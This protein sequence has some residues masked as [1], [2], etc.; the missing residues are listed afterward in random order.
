[1]TP[2]AGPAYVA[3]VLMHYVDLPDTP[4]RPTPQDQAIA[5]Q[6]YD[7]GVP[8]SLVEAALLL[9][10]LRRLIRPADHIAA[11]KLDGFREVCPFCQKSAPLHLPRS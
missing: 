4:M 11:G 2:I 3:S 9:A 8:L 1:M 10:S 5:R 6:L 7:Q